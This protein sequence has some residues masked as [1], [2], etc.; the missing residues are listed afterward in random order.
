MQK[1]FNS[2]EKTT[3]KSTAR[4]VARL[5]AKQEKLREQIKTMTIK[6]TE[7]IEEIDETI[8]Q[9]NANVQTITGGYSALDLCEKVSRGS[10]NDWVFKYPATIVPPV[11]TEVETEEKKEGKEEQTSTVE[12]QEE[13][14]VS[15]PEDVFG[16]EQ[17]SVED[18]F[19]EEQEDFPAQ[20]DDD[21][22]NPDEF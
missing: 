5:V 6:L 18:P 1:T 19:A 4:E 9:Y 20:E 2:Y 22:F 12:N 10:Q 14:H 17:L 7:E 11:Q 21:R 16:E 3:I 13:A 15:M 8:S